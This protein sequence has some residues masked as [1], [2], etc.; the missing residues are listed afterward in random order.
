MFNGS[1]PLMGFHIY[2]GTSREELVPYNYTSKNELFFN[3]TNV[4]Y[5]VPYYYLIN[6]YTDAG[7]SLGDEILLGTAMGRPMPPVNV[8]VNPG[9][10]YVNISW[11]P[12]KSDKGSNI[13]QYR[14]ERGLN[15]DSFYDLIIRNSNRTYYNDTF[16]DN[17]QLYYYRVFSANSIGESDPSS[18]VSAVPKKLPPTVNSLEY[19]PCDC[20]ANLTWMRSPDPYFEHFNVYRGTREL[21][22]GGLMG[23]YFSNMD[24]TNLSHESQDMEIDF[25]WGFDPPLP[26]MGDNQYSVRWEGY[27]KALFSGSYTIILKVDG[28]VRVW[29]DNIPIINTW[30]DGWHEELSASVYLTDGEH[31]LKIDYF[32]M[33][34]RGAIRLMWAPPETE[35]HVIPMESLFGYHITYELI[36]QTELNRYTDTDLEIAKAYYYYIRAENDA[37]ESLIGNIIEIYPIGKS[38]PPSAFDIEMGDGVVEL[39]WGPPS[40]FKG[41]EVFE[42]RIYRANGTQKVEYYA[43]VTAEVF[44]FNDTDIV[45]GLT[46]FYFV[47]AVNDAGESTPTTSLM[48]VPIGRPSPPINP[49]VELHAEG[50]KVSWASP[51]F[52]GGAVLRG[53]NVYRSVNGGNRTFIYWVNDFLVHAHIDPDVEGGNTYNY[54]ITALNQVGEST[55]SENV[56]IYYPVQ[57]DDDDVDDD[58]DDDQDKEG[59]FPT[60]LVI[61]MVIGL[62]L[63]IAIA[64]AAF[65][66]LRS[67]KEKKEELKIGPV[68]VGSAPG[69]GTDA[70]YDI[71][72]PDD[73][74]LDDFG[75]PLIRDLPTIQPNM[76]LP[77]PANGP[78]YP[79]QGYSRDGY[80]QG[81]EWLQQMP[82]QYQQ[83]Y[84]P[85]QGPEYQLPPEQEQYYE[86]LAGDYY[87]GQ[88][89]QQ[90]PPGYPPR[91]YQEN[92]PYPTQGVPPTGYQQGMGDREYYQQVGGGQEMG[93]LPPDTSMETP[94][95]GPLEGGYYQEDL[96]PQGVEYLDQMQ[97]AGNLPPGEVEEKNL[98]LPEGEEE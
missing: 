1:N 22:S 14:I 61:G 54:W 53:F 59:T 2:R 76:K 64:V 27:L 41:S 25:D 87:R 68:P 18:T 69:V 63:L 60:G 37:G 65:L 28:G 29:I 74:E 82:Q 62:L 48:A 33:E 90:G 94:Q 23:Y 32:N 92:Y 35:T 80:Q 84:P 67:N 3:D 13:T 36:A 16:V 40:N 79:P 98:R 6:S 7:E 57:G 88:P 75:Q 56:T 58:E 91:G 85:Q 72:H 70:T 26:R 66:Y 52:D 34:S 81:Q 20:G 44:S 4:S 21:I 45:N 78:G 5:G 11:K 86:Q 15:L 55:F 73:R 95:G 46:Y 17:R 50:L 71:F 9:D 77:A 83:G 47:T 43:N 8:T 24:H 89:P 12:P 39:T 31:L 96:G 97:T 10:H 38:T 42:Y 51:V 19:N 93:H 30:V 49:K